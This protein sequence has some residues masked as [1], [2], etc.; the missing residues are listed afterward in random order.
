MIKRPKYRRR[1]F[2][3]EEQGNF[4]YFSA[5]FGVY[6][7]FSAVGLF[8]K[9]NLCRF[10]PISDR[11]ADPIFSDWNAEADRSSIL[12][13]HHPLVNLVTISPP[14]HPPI[15]LVQMLNPTLTEHCPCSG[16]GTHCIQTVTTAKWLKILENLNIIVNY[17]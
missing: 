8:R 7:P 5:F 11:K 12:V 15:E 16:C 2:S 6:R 4:R 3:K 17:C 10:R 1:V 9:T 13:I 14:F